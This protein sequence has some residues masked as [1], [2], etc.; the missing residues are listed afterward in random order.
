[1]NSTFSF[2]IAKNLVAS[3]DQF[4]VD[5]DDA[6]EWLEYSRKDNAKTNFLKCGFV[7]G[8]DFQVSFLNGKN[9]LGGRPTEVIKMTCECLKQWGMMSGTAKGKEIRSPAL[10]LDRAG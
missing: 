9:P 5:F 2:E 1:M 7:E 3:T 4:P 6:W 8:I 10:V